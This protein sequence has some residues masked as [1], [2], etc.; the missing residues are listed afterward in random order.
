MKKFAAV[1]A[2]AFAACMLAR[3]SAAA[4]IEGVDFVK[5]IDVSGVEL[6]LSNVALLRYRVI[7]KGYVAGLYIADGAQ[8]DRLLDD[9]PK[10]LEI[11]YFWGIPSH[12]FAAVTLAGIAA[13]RP[14][15]EVDRLRP[16]IDLFNALY[17]D[18]EPGDRYALTY[19]PGVG[20]ELAHNGDPL[21]IVPGEDFGSAIFSIWFGSSPSDE[22]LKRRLLS[23]PGA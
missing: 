23:R 2:L 15:D 14:P 21:G 12:K 16:Q 13:N 5:E 20:T 4:Q 22:G 6:E 19:L 11:E 3:P 7:F 1:I 18:I 9:V 17:Q 10:R 8:P